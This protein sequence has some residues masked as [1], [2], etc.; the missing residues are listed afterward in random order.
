MDEIAPSAAA[1]QREAGKQQQER[2][3]AHRGCSAGLV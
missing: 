3:W 1:A 2:P